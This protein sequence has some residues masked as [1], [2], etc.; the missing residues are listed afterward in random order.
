MLD[1]IVELANDA[2]TADLGLVHRVVC[3][4]FFCSPWCWNFADI[5]AL[6]MWTLDPID[7]TKGF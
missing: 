4:S 7:G 1:R 5:F 2:L 6:G 3:G